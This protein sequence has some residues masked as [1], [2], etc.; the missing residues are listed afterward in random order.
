M[1]E[2]YKKFSFIDGGSYNHLAGQQQQDIWDEYNSYRDFSDEALVEA[3]ERESLG[4]KHG[5][6]RA[7]GKINGFIEGKQWMDLTITE[8]WLP[9]LEE[10]I[11]LF[12][13][14]LYQD[15]PK[16]FLD[17]ILPEKFHCEETK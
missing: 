7:N 8:Y 10:G 12:A 9:D 6:I 13:Y 3:F 17:R 4:I 2:I 14:E 11:T 1:A 5:I 15:F 16:W